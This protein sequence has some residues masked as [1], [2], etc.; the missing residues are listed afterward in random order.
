MYMTLLLVFPTLTLQILL[1]FFRV[2]NQKALFLLSNIFPPIVKIGVLLQVFNFGKRH[3]KMKRLPR[4][5]T[6]DAFIRILVLNQ[7]IV[8]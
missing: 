6:F 4:N 8:S 7:G 2:A 1:H 3:Y 5:E